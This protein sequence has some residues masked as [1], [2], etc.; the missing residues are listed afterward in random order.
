MACNC[1][2]LVF[3]TF[4]VM[5]PVT[6]NIKYFP[7]LKGYLHAFNLTK[8]WKSAEVWIIK[9]DLKKAEVYTSCKTN[10][11]VYIYKKL[12]LE[13]DC[14]VLFGR[15]HL[16]SMGLAGSTSLECCDTSWMFNMKML[17]FR[18]SDVVTKVS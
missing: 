15:R 7:G 17:F 4:N 14:V 10:F 13:V 9:F 16:L 11:T 3:L 18:T 2:A 1:Y 6:G 5:P 8:P 12:N